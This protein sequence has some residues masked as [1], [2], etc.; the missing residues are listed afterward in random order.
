MC[1]ES[2][3]VGLKET[4]GV[5][6]GTVTLED[7]DQTDCILVI[8]QN[9]GTNH[10]RMLAALQR[11]AR[12][13]CKILTVN[14][15]PEAGLKRFRHPQEPLSLIGSGTELTTLFL[16]VRINGDV[17]FLKGLLK[18][19]LD[20]EAELP[21]SVLDQAFIDTHTEGFDKFRADLEQA[22]WE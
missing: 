3:G 15:L 17:A 16:Q 7:F 13:R 21:G 2:S 9:P 18:A 14:P 1:H 22:S 8:G 19:L 20:K 12:N 11:A 4:I 6:K 5:G 10:P